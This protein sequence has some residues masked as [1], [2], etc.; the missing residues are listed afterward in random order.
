MLKEN[1]VA[2]DTK[3][4]Q[5]NKIIKAK[6]EEVAD[7]VQKIGTL[8]EISNNKTEQQLQLQDDYNT[9]TLKLDRA[10]EEIT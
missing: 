3:I 8:E 7:L 1:L 9:L 4:D 2:A 5:F 10:M 6:S